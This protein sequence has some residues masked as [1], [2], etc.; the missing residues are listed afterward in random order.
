MKRVSKKKRDVLQ[1]QTVSRKRKERRP[2]LRFG[3]IWSVCKGCLKGFGA[4]LVL[5]LISLSFLSVYHYLVTSPYLKLEHVKVKGAQQEL[6]TEILKTVALE[7]GVSLLALNL[8]ALKKQLEELRWIRSIQLERRFPHT[9]LIRVEKQ[10]PRAILVSDGM[11]YLNRYGEPF[12]KVEASEDADFP[13]VTG[14][15]TKGQ[16]EI[17]ELQ[18][19]ARVMEE[20]REE[21]NPW[22]LAALAEIHVEDE[23]HFT[24]YFEHMDAGIRV[25]GTALRKEVQEL[26]R[27]VAHLARSG[28]I[29]KVSTIDFGYRGGAV[30]SF[31]K[32]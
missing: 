22:S 19:V 25:S 9:L 16:R 2:A 12:K 32:G 15:R 23:N 28:R 30:V 3:M 1:R 29:G 13:L 21:K 31:R 6:K 17:D 20:L 4:V 5:A 7:P 8:Q 18:K 24:L 27:V 10:E 11:Y 26:R 14:L